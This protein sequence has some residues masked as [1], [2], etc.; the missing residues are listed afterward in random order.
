M[1][2]TITP[3]VTAA[4]AISTGQMEI[5]GPNGLTIDPTSA[6]DDSKILFQLQDADHFTL[7]VDQSVTN[8]PLTLVR[9][10]NL[11]ANRIWSVADNADTFNVHSATNVTGALT[12]GVDDT[13]HDVKFFGATA[14]RYMLWDESEDYLIFPDNVKAVFG[15]GADLQIYHDTNDSYIDDAGTGILFLRGNSAVKIGKYTG[16]ALIDANADGSV[17]LYYDNSAKL[18]THTSGVEITG[19]LEVTTIDYTDGD[20]AITI[21]DGGATTFAQTITAPS[22]EVR[23]DG[24]PAFIDFTNE[25]STDYD[26]R[27]Q[28][29]S[30]DLLTITGA[31]LG[32]AQI[33][34][35]D[36][37]NA[38]TIADGGGVTFDDT[39]DFDGNVTVGVDGT[40]HDVKFY[41]DSTGAYMLWDTS[42]NDL[43]VTAGIGGAASL[44]VN[45]TVN[46]AYL[47]LNSDTDEGQDSE[48]LFQTGG[49]TRGRIEYNHNTTANSQL[50]SFFTA[51]NA[52]ESL[53][54]QGNLATFGT[55]VDFDGNVTF[56]VDDTGVD[57]TFYGATS[58]RDMMWDES[59]NRLEFKDN[60]YLSFGTGADTQMYHTGS[61]FYTTTDTFYITSGT[62]H[63][64]IVSI[65][66]TNADG[67]P[68]YFNLIKNSSSPATTDTLG[69]I[70]FYGENAADEAVAMVKIYAHTDDLTDG[71][72]DGA[73]TI[74]ARVNGTTTS[75][76]HNTGTQ[77]D[78]V[79][80]NETSDI[81]LKENIQEIDTAID[82]IKKLRPVTFDWKIDSRSSIGFVAQDVEKILPTLVS[83]TK[84]N[85]EKGN[86]L[87]ELKTIHPSGILAHV[88]KALQESI[89]K[90]ETLEA[91]VK[92]LQEA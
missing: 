88:T 66:N 40:G 65:T 12:V 69:L 83:T 82:S 67:T 61:S 43:S 23:W 87:E 21:A 76:F 34:Y 3:R 85:D 89:E 1:A 80:L 8:D 22:I 60:T 50:M 41:G 17:V 15:T 7:G 74:Q 58:G 53:K 59:A 27:I 37:D 25:N 68:P 29:A 70:Q 91:Q 54:L 11:A 86:E 36:G 45:S 42:E 79:S 30:D 26:A 57:V 10:T 24:N 81:S 4:T 84:A 13:G 9:G 18:A 16:E 38:I 32:V 47:I 2:I 56:G 19:S 75:I 55:A 64:P 51:D 5:T 49:T 90:I 28:L 62:S 71:S 33:S 63:R 73:L 52:V 92:E 35:T 20:L 6:S 31:E 44:T 14:S 39:V 48:M 77:I 78:V 72:E 46:D